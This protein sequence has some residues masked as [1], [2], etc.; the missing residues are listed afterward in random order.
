MRHHKQQFF[1]LMAL[2]LGISICSAGKAISF[3]ISVGLQGVDASSL[4]NAESQNFAGPCGFNLLNVISQ[5]SSGI[6]EFEAGSKGRNTDAENESAGPS[7]AGESPE[8]PVSDD[9]NPGVE[10][11]AATVQSETP[12]VDNSGANA[13]APSPEPV[14]DNAP[15]RIE[16]TAP[17]TPVYSRTTESMPESKVSESAPA[18]KVKKVSKKKKRGRGSKVQDDEIPV[19]PARA[20]VPPP[21]TPAKSSDEEALLAQLVKELEYGTL[22][23]SIAFLNQLVTKCPEDP[24]YRS[25]LTMALRLRDGDVWYQYQRKVD[26]KEPEVVKIPASIMKPTPNETVNELKKSS[27]FLI[28]SVK[29]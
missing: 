10:Q 18:P 5:Q 13:E 11:S 8:T 15:T 16:R 1:L 26:Y 22:K 27:W 12:A 24:D 9:Q 25:L 20:V 7:S 23:N 17:A 21:T 28:R 4:R 29:R 14:S 19:A 6:L 2:T 3:D